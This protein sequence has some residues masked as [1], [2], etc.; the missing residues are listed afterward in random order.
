MGIIFSNKSITKDTSTEGVKIETDVTAKSLEF[1]GDVN[2]YILSGKAGGLNIKSIGSNTDTS[3]SYKHTF[4]EAYVL[5]FTG[6]LTSNGASGGDGAGM[7]LGHSIYFELI[8]SNQINTSSNSLRMIV[9]NWS[10]LTLGFK[11]DGISLDGDD[12]ASNGVNYRQKIKATASKLKIND[13]MN[14]SSGYSFNPS[15]TIPANKI[16]DILDAKPIDI[17][18]FDS[19][20]LD[21]NSSKQGPTL[22]DGF[23]YK[24]S[25][26]CGTEGSSQS[27]CTFSF[28]YD[29]RCFSSA[30][31]FL[32]IGECNADTVSCGIRINNQ[33][34]LIS[35]GSNSGGSKGVSGTLYKYPLKLVK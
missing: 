25:L 26:I 17:I 7:C 23:L 8:S 24:I 29:S 19:S 30:Q 14:N 20:N 18:S 5:D 16:I 9:S 27:S 21:L 35:R 11:I 3:F 22:E 1:T 28:I 2:I 10:G 31:Q 15:L 13:M 34:I 6:V 33:G 4:D 32:L 12:S